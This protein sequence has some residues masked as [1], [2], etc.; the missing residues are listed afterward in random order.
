MLAFNPDAS[1]DENA[2]EMRAAYSK[3]S[4][5]QV[6]FAARDS[7]FEGHDIKKGELLALLEGKLSFVDTDMQHCVLKL[8]KQMIK[9]DSS[10]VTVI[11]GEDVTDSQAA[12]LE[13]ALNNK[14]AGK[15]EFTFIKGMQPIYYFIIS[16][17]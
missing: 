9:R 8:A 13:T 3:V 11:Y 6:T 1:D 10:F 4:T 12:E 2:I 5:G 7:D 17:E 15:V 16:V 14:F